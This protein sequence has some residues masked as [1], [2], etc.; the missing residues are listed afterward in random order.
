MNPKADTQATKIHFREF[1]W[2]DPYKVERV[3]PNNNYIVRRLGTNKTQLHRIRLC[4]YKPQ[5]PLPDNLVRETEW[6][7][8]DTLISQDDLYA[9][10]WNTNFG[11]SPFETTLENCDQ[12]EDT[13]EYESTSQPEKYRPPPAH[14]N[15][16]NSGGIPAELPAVKNEEPQLF[17]KTP[18]ENESHERIPR[19]SR[20]PER[21]KNILSQFSPQTP[22]NNPEIDAQEA[23]EI[24]NTRSEKYHLRPDPNPNYSDSYR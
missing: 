12:Q 6:Q 15:F 4:K 9:H 1:R 16:E 17:E 21:S 18:S 22:E 23:E 14:N 7:M 5:A 24:V 19:T 8:E 11:S 13:V 20:N 3:L 2:V 10:T